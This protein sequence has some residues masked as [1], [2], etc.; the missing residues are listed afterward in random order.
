MIMM[1]SKINLLIGRF[2]GDLT[3]HCKYTPDI[4]FL[5]LFLFFGTFFLAFFLKK[6]KFTPF[7]PTKVK[8][9]RA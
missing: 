4:F 3:D 1:M 7:F 8:L 9:Y 2:G 6:F 5:S